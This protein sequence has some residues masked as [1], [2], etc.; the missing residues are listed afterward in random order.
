MTSAIQQD[1]R[2]ADRLGDWTRSHTCGTLRAAD[3]GTKVT[4]LGWV[5]RVRD[6]G[7]L[8]FVDVRDRD[9]LTQVVVRE[10]GTLLP[11]AKRLHVESVVGVRGTVR[12]RGPDAVNAR[13]PTGEIEVEAEDIRLLNDA[14][15]PPFQIADETEVADDLRLRY[16]YLD[17][18]RPRLQANLRLRHSVAMAVRRYFDR[19][20]FLEIETPILTKSTP[21]G[22]RDYLVPSRVHPGEFYALPQSPQLFKQ[23]LMIAGVDRYF[24]IV[25]CFRDEDLRSDRQ[26][27]FTQVDVEISFATRD[28]VFSVIEPLMQEVFR[29][30]GQELALPL[31]RIPYSEAI[32]RYGS[33]KP[34]LRFGMAIEGLSDA[35]RQAPFGPF[36][37][38]LGAGGV[39]RGFAVTGAA[40]YSRRDLDELAEQARQAGLSTLVW[41][42][43]TSEGAV[44]SSALKAAGEAPIREALAQ[45]GARPGDLV[46]M[47]AGQGEATSRALGA[48]RLLIARKEELTRP[49]QFA[50]VWVVDFPL[51]EWNQ[52]EGRWD[53]VQHPFTAPL[54]QDTERL[55]SDPGSVRGRIYDL[56]LNGWEIGGG[57]IRIHDPSLQARVFRLLNIGEEEARERFGF[58]LEALGYGTPPHGGIA[59]G[60]DR[61]VAMLAGEASIREVIAFPKTAAAVDLMAGAPSKVNP[62]QLKEL[63][64]R[65]DG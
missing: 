43:L 6:L 11:L 32:A 60:L 61:I 59:L 28:L 55:E 14:R 34:D 5:H 2:M 58:F 56:V 30:I 3:I 24:Q 4:L 29:E 57:S 64:L 26:P 44:Q 36:R 12:A 21:E 54:D 17:L 1:D 39:V 23:L 15:T 13:M 53:S 62:R 50:M 38:A 7:A 22:A 19:Q 35:F 25:R 18:R 8:L 41:A 51:L 63:R 40:R 20:G 37:D 49:D 33:D 48:L 31:R 65:I 52:E 10:G 16:R 45:S 9:G 27:E 47:S 46:L 42:R